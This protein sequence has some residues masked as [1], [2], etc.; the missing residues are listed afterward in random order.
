M[1]ICNDEITIP[2][3]WQCPQCGFILTRNDFHTQ[4]TT[5]G[6]ND[7]A[8]SARCPND[9]QILKPETWKA[10]CERL[11]VACERLLT[12]IEWL[13]EFSAFKPN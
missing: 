12:K 1:T 8:F 13:K 2:G 9:G 4:D 11:T 6:P 10:R 3:S 7:E 5:V